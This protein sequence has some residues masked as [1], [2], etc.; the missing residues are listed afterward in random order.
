MEGSGAVVRRRRD[1]EATRR[2]VLDAVVATVIEVGY[3][4][5]SSNEIARRAGVSWG[6]IDHLFGSR[7]QLMLDVVNDLGVQLEQG[8]AA[9][10]VEGSTLEER[11]G[12]VFD[13]LARHYVH[14]RFLVQMLIL[15][16]LSSNPRMASRRDQ[17]GAREEGEEFD[18]LAQPLFAKALGDL[19]AEHD[20]VVFAFLMMRGY[21]TTVAFG[22]VLAGFPDDTIVKL[23]DQHTDEATVRDLLIRSIAA[24]LRD[25]AKQ[26]GYTL[27]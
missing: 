21:L 3:Y 14:H 17:V 12:S 10:T 13:A 19:A 8:L 25:E 26:R 4:K 16:E 9:E 2:R 15:L 1:R 18:R 11:L 20:L 27:D 24:T 23:M 5:A 6:S 7:E 22:R